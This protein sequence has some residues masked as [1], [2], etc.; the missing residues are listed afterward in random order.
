VGMAARQGWRGHTCGMAVELGFWV[1]HAQ[2]CA[3]CCSRSGQR[4]AAAGHGGAA[5]ATAASIDMPGRRPQAEL[6]LP[7]GPKEHGEFPSVLVVFSGG[8]G[9]GCSSVVTARFA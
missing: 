4:L 5:C 3:L 2:I 8:S 9:Y 6:V 1:L 7:Y